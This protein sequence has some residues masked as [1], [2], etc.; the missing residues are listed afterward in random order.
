MDVEIERFED[1]GEADP[2]GSVAYA[3]SGN[4]YHF[5][6]SK[7]TLKGRRYDDTPFEAFFLCWERPYRLFDRVPTDA[8]FA[9]AVRYFRAGGVV[10]IRVLLRGGYRSV[11]PGRY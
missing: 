4:L 11:D 8:L 10:E 9:D 1:V 3:Y 5:S 6:D 7:R 2:D